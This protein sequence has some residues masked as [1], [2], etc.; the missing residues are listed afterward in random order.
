MSVTERIARVF[1]VLG[2]PERLKIVAALGSGEAC[3]CHLEA[4]L[5]Y[6]QAYL[7]QQLMALRDASLVASRREGRF[8]FYRLA[9]PA[10]L[11]L[12]WQVGE[13]LGMESAELRAL[14]AGGRLPGCSCPACEPEAPRCV[15]EPAASV[16]KKGS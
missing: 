6:R 3:V 1:H 4:A 5:G 15:Y 13:G 16:L 7:S 14:Q 11:E 12:I 9:D 10:S 2:Q 8:I